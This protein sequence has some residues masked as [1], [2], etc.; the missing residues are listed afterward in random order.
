MTELANKVAIVTGG[1]A[2]I[3]FGIAQRLASEGARVVIADINEAAGHQAVAALGANASF[4]R[5]DVADQQQLRDLV[6]HVAA[7]CGRLDIMINNAGIGGAN[8][9]RLLDDDL[10]DFHQ[11]MA[12]D[13]L[14]VMAG[15][16]E[17]ARVMQENGGG[18]I[19]NISSIG[20]INASAG[21]WTYHVA[22]SS[23]IMFTKCAAIDLGAMN[24]RVNAIAPGNI[25][26]EILGRSMGA[27]LSP[28]KQA[29]LAGSLRQFIISRQALKRQ[30]KVE[31]IAE[32]V[33][34]FVTDRSRYVTGTLLPVDGGLVAGTAR[35]SGGV[36]GLRKQ[37]QA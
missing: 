24:I 8:H 4:W 34:F 13:L 20:G 17:A 9:P 1:S 14:G 7:D 18:S 21:N 30:G 31:D 12:I 29:E 32:A 26:T 22:K 23:V 10:S 16:R 25:E 36:E 37:A 35:S 28:E 33:L 6:D 2:G 19:V 15:T 27:N 11:V 3:G 5:T